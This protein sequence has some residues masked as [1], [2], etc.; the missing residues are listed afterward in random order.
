VLIRNLL[1]RLSFQQA[2]AIVGRKR[3]P[4]CELDLP[5]ISALVESKNQEVTTGV[6]QAL[7]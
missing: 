1:K 7:T 4:P 5:Y 6:K 3:M 2:V